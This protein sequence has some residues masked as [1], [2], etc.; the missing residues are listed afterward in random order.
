MFVR[1]VMWVVVTCRGQNRARPFKY[2]SQLCFF[3]QRWVDS[4]DMLHST[5]RQ[6]TS[7]WRVILSCCWYVPFIVSFTA[8]LSCC[9]ASYVVITCQNVNKS[10]VRTF[11]T[12]FL[13]IFFF[14]DVP[15]DLIIVKADDEQ[16]TLTS[17]RSLH[18]T[19]KALGMTA[20]FLV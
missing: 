6:W 12:F 3:T 9:L 19:F 17:K 14:F 2:N 16:F 10:S 1:E 15:Q 20:E 18:L 13:K 8:V 4:N 5:D 11:Q 7:D